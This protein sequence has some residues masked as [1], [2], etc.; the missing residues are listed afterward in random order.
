MERKV[1]VGDKVVLKENL[2]Q[3]ENGKDSKDMQPGMIYEV[4]SLVSGIVE[5]LQGHVRINVNGFEYYLYP[6][7][8]E[9]VGEED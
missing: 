4:S 2:Y 1:K 6:S 5:N 8:Y 3:K 7:E 9:L